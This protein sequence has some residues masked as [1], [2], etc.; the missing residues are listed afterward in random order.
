MADRL[1]SWSS[2]G[3]QGS[4]VWVDD[5]LLIFR[6]LPVKPFLRNGYPYRDPGYGTSPSG[7]HGR[8]IWHGQK[9]ASWAGDT[10][11]AGYGTKFNNQMQKYDKTLHDN[12][13]VFMML[14]RWWEQEDRLFDGIPRREL[15]ES[16]NH[17]AKITEN[18]S[19]ITSFD[20][21]LLRPRFHASCETSDL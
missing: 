7:R 10:V 19:S 15:F 9:T 20:N 13:A 21:F 14:W 5:S 17:Y 3:R 2:L 11:H 16:L 6:F 12:R 4:D 1:R 8:P 18:G